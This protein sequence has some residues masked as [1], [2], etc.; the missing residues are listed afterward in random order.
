MF[1]NVEYIK[2][3]VNGLKEFVNSKIKSLPQS[4]WDQNDPTAKDYV[5]NRT[6]WV[7]NRYRQKDY[8]ICLNTDGLSS[9]ENKDYKNGVIPLVVGEQVQVSFVTW[10]DG[11]ISSQCTAIVAKDAAG[12]PCIDQP[13]GLPITIY[14]DHATYRR[15]WVVTISSGHVIV[16]RTVALKHVHPID[17][18]YLV[19]GQEKICWT[20]PGLTELYTNKNAEFKLNGTYFYIVTLPSID[21]FGLVAG[22]KYRVVWDEVSYDCTCVSASR[23]GRNFSWIGSPT[24]AAPYNEFGS[25]N[26]FPFCISTKRNGTKIEG[27]SVAASRPGK[28]SFILY[29]IGDDIVYKIPD[30]YIPHALFEI[31]ASV[32]GDP[33]ELGNF[34]VTADKS[35]SDILDALDR[36]EVPYVNF[37]GQT[38]C[39]LNDYGRG[40]A[41]FG[42]GYPGVEDML[43]IIVF[44]NGED[45]SGMLISMPTTEMIGDLNSLKTNVKDSLVSAINEAVLYTP[46]TLTDE[47]KKQARLNISALSTNSVAQ[48][49]DAAFHSDIFKLAVNSDFGFITSRSD[50]FSVPAFVM[51]GETDR[52][53]RPAFII[54]DTGSMFKTTLNLSTMAKPVLRE[55]PLLRLNSDNKFAQQTM[56]S[57][58]T[59]DMQIATKKYVDDHATGGTDMG[60][61]GATVGQIAK[62]TAVDDTGKPTAWSPVDM[63]SGGSSEDMRVIKTITITAD[64][65]NSIYFNRDDNGLPFAL[66]KHIRIR[67]YGAETNTGSTQSTLFF[68]AGQ[69]VGDESQSIYPIK[70]NSN[71]ANYIFDF[72]WDLYSTVNCWYG[73]F[74]NARASAIGLYRYVPSEGNNSSDIT[75]REIKLVWSNTSVFFQNGATIVVEGM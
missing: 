11:S 13:I 73:D 18:E 34:K 48:F 12:E 50:E 4:N 31:K 42:F 10:F 33:D 29:E 8:L 27:N 61:T 2:T 51:F 25:G 7:E 15:D 74:A 43:I 1:P 21:S 45:S 14:A 64:G 67:M 71:N 19:N 20:E 41:F 58:P 22:K 47:Q 57:T 69:T 68:R 9:V 40:N 28:H 32:N 49:Y 35:E 16:T 23:Y 38:L 30:K 59:E 26:S 36:G 75:V 37:E 3:L 56:A 55:I 60:I 72:V 65:V 39:W 6:H 24:L 5:K 53:Y 54:D 66:T 52:G 70:V 62:I 63:P 44:I 46:Q 17:E